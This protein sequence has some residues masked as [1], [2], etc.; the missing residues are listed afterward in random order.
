MF[1][2]AWGGE[3]MEA[4]KKFISLLS[5]FYLFDFYIFFMG[6]NCLVSFRARK[7]DLDVFNGFKINTPQKSCV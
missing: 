1:I 5:F 4:V 3:E 7:K 6:E 2:G